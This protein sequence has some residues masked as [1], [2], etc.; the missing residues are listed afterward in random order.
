MLMPDRFTRDSGV[1]Q[2]RHIFIPA[3]ALYL[4]DYLAINIL[5]PTRDGT[6]EHDLGHS[7]FPFRE[8]IIVG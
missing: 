1:F 7:V 3:S 2:R 8:Y 6:G 4:F 5:L